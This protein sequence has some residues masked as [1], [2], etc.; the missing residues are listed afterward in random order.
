MCSN[1][2]APRF[3]YLLVIVVQMLGNH[4]IVAVGPLDP[5]SDTLLH[6]LVNLFPEGP[7]TQVMG[8]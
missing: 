2:W 4:M 8:Y 6:T 5:S 1:S 3:W 7:R